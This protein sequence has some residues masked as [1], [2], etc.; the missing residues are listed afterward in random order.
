V[1]RA[2]K[3]EGN[4]IITTKVE[5]PAVLE[6]CRDLESDGYIV[7]YLDVDGQGKLDVNAALQAITDQTIL[8]SIMH[9]NNEA[10]TVYPIEE[11]ARKVKQ[12]NPRIVF[13]SDGVQA[14][15]KLRINLSDIDLYSI[16][17]HKFHAPK[18]VGALVV[19]EGVRL[20]SLLTG[21]GHER[22]L[23][24]GTENVPG[25]VGLA[26]AIELA[27]SD[28]EKKQE[29]FKALKE[30]FVTGL[31]QIPGTRINSPSDGVPTTVSVGFAG[32][33]AE[34]LLNALGDQGICVS[35]GSA[36]SSR[37]PHGRRSHVLQAM[38]LEPR[39]IDSTLRFSFSRFTTLE[40]IDEALRVLREVIPMLQAVARRA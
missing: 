39:L 7:T 24:S 29:Y 21:G 16:S 6:S 12:A 40:E 9:V 25:I 18:G 38:G 22:G 28:F 32:A 19:R 20:K 10:G 33:P 17:G 14:I 15:G 31:Q 8:V 30:R 5:H 11:I 13:H 1:A 36:C 3:R 37:D 27:Y 23:R 26:K 35:A 4:H 34:V 2:L